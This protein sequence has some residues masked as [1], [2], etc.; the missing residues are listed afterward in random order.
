MRALVVVIASACMGR[1][2]APGEWREVPP[3]APCEVRILETDGMGPYERFERYDGTGRLVFGTTRLTY[4][5][6]GFE[7]LTWDGRNVVRVDSYYDQ[8]FR[9]GACAV[10]GGCDEPARRT[11][12][13]TRYRYDRGRLVAAE[14][15]T[16]EFRQ[17]KDRA[18]KLHDRH[19]HGD[20]YAYDGDR[21][22]RFGGD[23]TYDNGHAAQRRHGKYVDTFEWQG[24]RLA[25]YRWS[26]Y[27][28]AFEYDD[29]GRL[30]R[31]QLADP[32]DTDMGPKTTEWSYDDAGRLIARVETQAYLRTDAVSRHE[33]RWE[34]GDA[35]RMLRS[36][37]DA[38]SKVYTYG[39]S[40]PASLHAPYV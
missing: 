11:I 36:S 14:D 31:E 15:T 26:G 30:A 35:G 28:Q 21:L 29:R 18:W 22:V 3:A 39:A 9:Q 24:D 20:D 34:Y 16:L 19:T 1:S 37:A 23:I 13:H 40:C 10:I 6:R 8:D 33:W 12:D 2:L 17:D 5:G 25:M 32:K 38:T 7:Y 4:D 27:Q